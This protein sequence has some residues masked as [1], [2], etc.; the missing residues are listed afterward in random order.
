MHGGERRA[1]HL[2]RKLQS[3]QLFSTDLFATVDRGLA[4]RSPPPLH[5]K[6]NNPGSKMELGILAFK[7][8]M[9]SLITSLS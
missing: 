6:Q 2:W 4:V 3:P 1:P 7:L 8:I 5:I 9:F